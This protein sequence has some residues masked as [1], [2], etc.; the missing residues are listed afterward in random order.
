M[1]VVRGKPYFYSQPL[2]EASNGSMG[3]LLHKR[4]PVIY[5]IVILLDCI[6]LHYDL[7]YIAVTESLPVPLLLLYMM[8]G[9][10][11]IAHPRGKFFFYIG[12]IATFLGDV[13]QIVSD[14][15]T[16]LLGT[17][18]A[19]LLMNLAYIISM[20]HL[21]RVQLKNILSM[22]LCMGILFA[23]GYA[24]IYFIG[25]EMGWFKNLVIVYM[26][27]L[28]IMITLTVNISANT[29]YYSIAIRNLIPGVLLLLIL[30]VLIGLNIF[31]YNH[32]NDVYAVCMLLEAIAN[33]LL[34][35]GMM[36]IYPQPAAAV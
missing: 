5:W 24:F 9:D 26:C 16:F 33:F 11:R 6:F 22:L 3:Y 14:N 4:I 2:S 34:V 31:H 27:T 21:N 32:S 7:S 15:D 20:Y 36:K 35:K 28:G 23:I 12:L 13:S 19:F 25:D 29:T 10:T 1:T 8:A 30:N 17:I 18:I